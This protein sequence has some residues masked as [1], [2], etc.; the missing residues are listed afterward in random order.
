MIIRLVWILVVYFTYLI[1]QYVIVET[2]WPVVKRLLKLESST[3]ITSSISN[4]KNSN[5]KTLEPSSSVQN[6]T[7]HKLLF[8]C[9]L[10]FRALL[11]TV[12]S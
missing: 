12:T 9:E 6:Q 10:V 3:N 5:E 2:L 1:Q 8:P 4:D 7:E 11:V